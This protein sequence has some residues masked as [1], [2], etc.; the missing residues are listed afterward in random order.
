MG[1]VDDRGAGAGRRRFVAINDNGDKLVTGSQA[2]ANQ[3]A[4]G[5][6]PKT[7]TPRASTKQTT[8]RRNVVRQAQQAQYPMTPYEEFGFPKPQNPTRVPQ[9]GVGMSSAEP[10]TPPRFGRTPLSPYSEPIGPRLPPYSQPI[11]PSLGAATRAQVYNGPQ[12]IQSANFDQ[13]LA[14]FLA[15]QNGQPAPFSNAIPPTFTG[16]APAGYGGGALGNPAGLP[17]GPQMP[18]P[19]FTGTAPTTGYAGGALGAP[20]AAAQAAASSVGPASYKAFGSVKPT[21]QYSLLSTGQMIDPAT[22]LGRFQGFMAGAPIT[23]AIPNL[24]SGLP[25]FL[26][27]APKTGLG[28]I[29]LGLGANL[30]GSVGGSYVDQSNLFG[31]KD[32]TAN[33]AVSAALRGAG[34]GV[35][36][37]MAVPG[38]GAPL[39]GLIGA[40]LGAGYSLLKGNDGGG[41]QTAQD[42]SFNDRVAN[43]QQQYGLDAEKTQNVIDRFDFRMQM[44]AD[45]ED[46]ATE[47]QKAKELASSE[48]QDLVLSTIDQTDTTAFNPS[49]ALAMQALIGNY[50]KPYSDM[51]V[52][53][54]K[55]VASAYEQVAATLG[56]PQLA[57]RARAYGA[58]AQS[59]SNLQAST[60]MA[61]GMTDPMLA[62]A[63]N[64]S[65][66]LSQLNQ[67]TQ[68]RAMAAQAMPATSST[69]SL[70]G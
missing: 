69:S 36:L 4:S 26:K 35:G 47:E 64:Q 61:A 17:P 40:G 42:V 50:V 53:S 44:A 15:R 52:Q 10:V 7:A 58:D 5:S 25:N 6:A 68:A 22:R 46:P 2:K 3:H 60:L 43:F 13:K 11:G 55:D 30:I 31:G 23:S 18:P 48:L 70:L 39:G 14:A 54:G 41:D 62:A 8:T 67:Q 32:S 28:N 16:T 12:V 33:D 51:Y 9:Y 27:Y 19:A 49:D 34:I 57:A 59:Y 63:K 29:G 20:V 45:S 37:G 21:G 66:M 56:D 24:T 38:I 65:D 1:S